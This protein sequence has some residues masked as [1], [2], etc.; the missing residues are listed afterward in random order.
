MSRKRRTRVL[1]PREKLSISIRAPAI[2]AFTLQ[3]LNRN[4]WG[5]R[6]SRPAPLWASRIRAIERPHR[7]LKSRACAK[8]ANEF[9]AR[10]IR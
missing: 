10:R 6:Y 2:L 8:R 3:A 9:E 5:R 1:A 7:A 4:A